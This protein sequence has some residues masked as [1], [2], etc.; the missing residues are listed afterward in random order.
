MKCSPA[1]DSLDSSIINYLE[2]KRIGL[3]TNHT[4][5]TIDNTSA[6]DVLRQLRLNVTALFSPEHGP[7]GNQEGKVLSSNFG[8]LP[9]HSL[10]GETRQPTAEILAQIDVFI[11]DLQDVGARFYTYSSTLALA[12]ET[13]AKHDVAVVVLDRPNPLGGLSVVGPMRDAANSSFIGHL[14]IPIIHGM[15]MGEL[16]LLHRADQN[17]DLDLQIAK[18]QGWQRDLLWPQL[19]LQWRVPSPNLPDFAS[20]AWYPGL[21]LLE[22][23]GVSVG[24]GTDAPFQILGAPWM[25]P[26]EVLSAMEDW[27]EPLKSTFAVEEVSFI[28]SRG[29]WEDESC[30]GLRFSSVNLPEPQSGIHLGMALLAVLHQTNPKQFNA[31]KSLPLLGS[32]RVL[33]LLM[34]NQLEEA[35]EI[36]AIDAKS[37]HQKRQGFLIYDKK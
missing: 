2:K 24:R 13:C 3:L 34:N 1:L 4:S 27:L 10:Y 35:F 6:L 11:C 18:I 12:M 19:N 14:D 37:F 32:S 26:T 23:S 17:L 29:K 15:T 7:A 33:E 28:P 8:D 30:K 16:A 20:A 9:V 31:Q 22:F 21:C 25:N 5:C 36:A